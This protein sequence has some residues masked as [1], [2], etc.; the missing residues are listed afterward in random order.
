MSIT[1]NIIARANRAGHAAMPADGHRGAWQLTLD[2]CKPATF[3]AE[4]F[5]NKS[6]VTSPKGNR[7][8]GPPS[9]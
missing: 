6:Y 3:V 1:A 2:V 7:A 5:N 9:A 8:W 4:T